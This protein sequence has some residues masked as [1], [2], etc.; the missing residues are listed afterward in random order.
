MENFLD[1]YPGLFYM[2]VVWIGLV[3]VAGVIGNLLSLSAVATTASL[4]TSTQL[5]I[6]ILAGVDLFIT[7]VLAPCR[8]AT[9]YYSGRWP[10]TQP[11]CHFLAYA[12]PISVV[13]SLQQLVLI[14]QNRFLRV[15]KSDSVY[16]KFTS[17]QVVIGQRV[18]ATSVACLLILLPL[19][20]D[21]GSVGYNLKV[22]FCFFT[23]HNQQV[24]TGFS[25]FLA[26]V[27]IPFFYGVTF[28]HVR[29]H[30]RRVAVWSGMNKELRSRQV[31]TDCGRPDGSVTELP[32]QT[33]LPPTP[34]EQSTGTEKANTNNKSINHSPQDDNKLNCKRQ[35]VSV[36]SGQT[37]GCSAVNMSLPTAG[38]SEAQGN[39]PASVPSNAR[40]RRTTKSGPTKHGVKITRNLFLIFFAYI[41]CWMPWWILSLTELYSMDIPIPLYHVINNMLWTNSCINPY[42]YASMSRNYRNAI[43]RCLKF[44]CLFRR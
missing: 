1:E 37:I 22:H 21:F 32:S 6:T 36:I 28:H 35:T 40:R 43:K 3:S 15:T 7:G 2:D 31:D 29:V 5:H 42:L 4:R 17:K 12:I 33:C 24:F 9:E 13:F 30:Q 14:A 16:R 18:I 23:G 38:T 10:R 8:I 27:V 25:M 20:T 44:K 19:Y 41:C 26:L 11:W 39:R 34:G